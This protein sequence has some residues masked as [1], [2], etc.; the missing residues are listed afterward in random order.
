[1]IKLLSRFAVAALLLMSV[2]AFSG[3]AI[4]RHF[5]LGREAQETHSPEPETATER[6]APPDVTEP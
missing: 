3:C 4:L 1:M 5:I 2:T 6:P